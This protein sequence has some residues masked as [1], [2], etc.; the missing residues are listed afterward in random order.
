[1][2]SGAIAVAKIAIAALRNA[3]GAKSRLLTPLTRRGDFS[4]TLLKL[5]FLVVISKTT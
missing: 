2:Q 1:L 3:L 4:T 5:Q